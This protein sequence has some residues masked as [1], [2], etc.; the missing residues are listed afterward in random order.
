MRDVLLPQ[1]LR[2]RI[3]SEVVVA[4][5]QTHA[6][7]V[8]N[9]HLERSV[10]EVRFRSEAEKDVDANRMELRDDRRE[11]AGRRHGADFLQQRIE[12][13]D[14]FRVDRLLVHARRVVVADLL[15]LGI[16]S[17]RGGGALQNGFERLV[18]AILQLVE[19][20]PART[21]GGNRVVRDPAAAGELEE[22]GARIGAPI[23][24][25]ELQ[26]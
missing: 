1:L 18:V 19:P 10:F 16:A 21:I 7:P 24:R 9:R 14:P 13:R 5:G 23:Q 15:R 4:L 26:P 2:L 8:G 6:A 3:V 20:P 17:A 22:V 11:L 12:R 25:V